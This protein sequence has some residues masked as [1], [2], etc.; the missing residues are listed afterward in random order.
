MKASTEEK[1][2]LSPEVLNLLSN[3]SAPATIFDEE[4]NLYK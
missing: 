4:K 1:Q 2:S 3:T